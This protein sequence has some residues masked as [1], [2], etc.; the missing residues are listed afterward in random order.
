VF[1]A[2]FTS[3]AWW[4]MGKAAWPMG[5]AMAL[6]LGVSARFARERVRSRRLKLGHDAPLIAK[7]ES[8]IAELRHQRLLLLGV[9][10]WYLGPILLAWG[11]VVATSLM[12]ARRNAPPGMF[13]DLMRNPVTAAYLVSYFLVVVPLCFWGTWSLNRRAV[14]RRIEP[15]LEELEKMRSDL[16]SAGE[17]PQIYS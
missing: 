4:K 11:F 15:R 16:L 8:Q 13:E 3:F 5:I 6:I 10:K 12:F 14:R 9:W 17:T 2:A 7:L 1:F